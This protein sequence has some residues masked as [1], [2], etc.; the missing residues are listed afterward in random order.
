MYVILL[1]LFFINVA[2]DIGKGIIFDENNH[3]SIDRIRKNAPK[4]N[5]DFDLNKHLTT[6]LN[7]TI[8]HSQFPNRLKEAQVV[9]LHKKNDPL[10][11]KKLSSCQY[12]ANNFKNL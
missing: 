12:S 3:P 8:K 11:K 9:P 6:L 4:N 2:N 5:I 10:D 1:I 7:N